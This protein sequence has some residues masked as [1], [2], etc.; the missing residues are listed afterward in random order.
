MKSSATIYVEL[1]EE[2]TP[3]W[4][5]VQ[6][7]SVGGE[8][9]RIIEEKPQGEKW[10]FSKDDIVKCR[11]RTFQQADSQLTAYEKAE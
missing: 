6:A 7:I 2:G 11:M 8:L 9:Y 1:L 5:P 10:A 4:K 3:C